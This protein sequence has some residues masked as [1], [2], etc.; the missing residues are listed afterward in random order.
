MPNSKM[1]TTLYSSKLYSPSKTLEPNCSSKNNNEAP[2]NIRAAIDSAN[3]REPTSESL[4]IS[5]KE[6]NKLNFR[7]LKK[8]DYSKASKDYPSPLRTKCPLIS[9]N[10]FASHFQLFKFS[11]S[12]FHCF[13]SCRYLRIRGKGPLQR[14]KRKG[15]TFIKLTRKFLII[16]TFLVMIHFFFYLLYKILFQG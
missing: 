14:R 2:T 3:K 10:C 4:H 12:I 13:V 8:N 15:T 7:V 5:V 11:K 6:L 16:L 9:I 1:K